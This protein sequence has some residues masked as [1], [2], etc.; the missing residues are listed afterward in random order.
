MKETVRLD[1][2][3]YKVLDSTDGNIHLERFDEKSKM[4]VELIFPCSYDQKAHDRLAGF[5]VD[6]YIYQNILHPKQGG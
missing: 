3:E 4:F 2:A 5:M 6:M 1:G